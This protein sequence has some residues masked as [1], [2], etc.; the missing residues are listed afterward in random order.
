[1]KAIKFTLFG[2]GACF[3][4]PYQN[5][6]NITYSHIHKIAL[7]GILG[8][9]IGLD[10][11]NDIESMFNGFPPKKYPEFYEELKDLKVSIVPNKKEFQTGIKT[12]TDTTGAS[13]YE[14]P[15]SGGGKYGQTLIV[16]EQ[17]LMLPSWDIYIL[18]DNSIDRET[19][20]YLQKNLLEHNSVY[21]IYFGK[22]SYT[23]DYKDVEIVKISTPD[24]V[25][26]LDSLFFYRDVVLADSFGSD[27]IPYIFKQ[28]MPIGYEEGTCRYI[29]EEIGFTES[30]IEF[31]SLKNVYKHENRILQ[32]F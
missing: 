3:R 29:Q 19:F 32:F 15:K 14:V 20:E 10:G 17:Y 12:Y 6:M 2:E 31:H 28:Y 8:A 18:D 5:R 9:I 21:Y 23:A 24:K 1:M 27:S 22:N 11:L 26:K 13:S 25:S 4:A 7:L 30:M 16:K